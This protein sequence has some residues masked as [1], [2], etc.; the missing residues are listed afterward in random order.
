MQHMPRV[1]R[2]VRRRPNQEES[3]VKDVPIRQMVGRANIFFCFVTDKMVAACAV[4]G[5]GL[6]GD[7]GTGQGVVQGQKFSAK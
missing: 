4:C 3:I 2:H 5:K 1:A 7:K 6:S